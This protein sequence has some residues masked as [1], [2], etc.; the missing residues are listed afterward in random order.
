LV[1]DFC[2]RSSLSA[3]ISTF[4]FGNKAKAE[5]S[6]KQTVKKN[7]SGIQ[8]GGDFSINSNNDTNKDD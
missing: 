3:L 8:V 2:K 4:I 5:E 6:Q 7:S 1:Y